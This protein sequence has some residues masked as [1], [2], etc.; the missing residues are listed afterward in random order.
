MLEFTMCLKPLLFMIVESLAAAHSEPH[1]KK[2]AVIAYA[3]DVTII[4]TSPKGIPIVQEALRCYEDA[5]GA[6]QNIQKSKAMALDSW[7]ISHTIMGITYIKL[8]ILGLKMTTTIQKS[9]IS[10]W[11]TVMGNIR[12]QEQDA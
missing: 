7:D 8:R 5:T 3:D 6:K 2:T 1:N 10:R 9:A 4:L 12:A 11:R